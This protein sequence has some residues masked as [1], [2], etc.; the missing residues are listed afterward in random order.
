MRNSS[1]V[2]VEQKRGARI[3][4]STTFIKHA[5]K[6]QNFFGGFHAKHHSSAWVSLLLAGRGIGTDNLWVLDVDGVE[7]IAYQEEHTTQTH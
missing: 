7:T 1:G 2:V 3:F 6:K 5:T 4:S